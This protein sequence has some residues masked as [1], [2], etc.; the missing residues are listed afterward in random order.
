MPQCNRKGIVALTTYQ[1]LRMNARIKMI[2]AIGR[3]LSDHIR[4]VTRKLRLP[5]TRD[6]VNGNRRSM[7]AYRRY[8]IG[9]GGRN[10]C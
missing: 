3:A 10:R 6:I 7:Y 1:K 9:G 2:I 8:A 5:V 4:N